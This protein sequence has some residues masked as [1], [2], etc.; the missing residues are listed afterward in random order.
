M[1]FIAWYTTDAFFFLFLSA[2]SFYSMYSNFHQHSF[3]IISSCFPELW[4]WH[5]GRKRRWR[6]HY[7][8]EWPRRVP[9]RLLPLRPHLRRLRVSTTSATLERIKKKMKKKSITKTWQRFLRVWMIQRK[10]VIKKKR[11]SDCCRIKNIIRMN[12]GRSLMNSIRRNTECY[13]QTSKCEPLIMTY[14][15]TQ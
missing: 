13:E 11:N 12:R 1:A 6:L 9:C 10:G 14:K 8:R 15:N 3:K 4:V 5:E 7:V 2:P